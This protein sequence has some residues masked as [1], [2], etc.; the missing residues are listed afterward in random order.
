MKGRPSQIE[1]KP[2]RAKALLVKR[3]ISQA[4]VLKALKAKQVIVSASALSRYLNYGVLPPCDYGHLCFELNVL[5]DDA[6]ANDA[7]EPTNP[8]D[9]LRKEMLTQKAR[10]HFKLAADPF[11][12]SVQKAD[13]VFFTPGHRYIAQSL[14]YCAKNGDFMAVVG[15]SGS[16]KSVLR[17]H[18]IDRVS[19]PDEKIIVIQPR[20]VDKTRLTAEHICEAIVAHFSEKPKRSKEALA[21][22]IERLLIGSTKAGFS[23]VV[24]IEEAHDLATATLKYLKRFWE[25]EYGFKQLLGIAL[26]GQ[27]ELLQKLDQRNWEVREVSQRCQIAQLRPLDDAQAVSGFLGIKFKRIGSD[28]DAVIDPRAMD[29][30]GEKLTLVRGKERVSL[31]YPLAIQNL[32]T[33][34]MNEAAENGERRITAESVRAL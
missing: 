10:E 19:K 7:Q 21:A 5:C 34:A 30:I 18:F 33:R 9:F 16:G 8:E 2:L 15:E 24:V 28:L 1:A 4:D 31:C 27:P 29:A 6:Q 22:Q 14:Y 12:S 20:T 32:V 25:L 26:I 23:H 13:D 3:G 11:V 17:K